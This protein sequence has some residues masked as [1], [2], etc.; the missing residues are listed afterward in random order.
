VSQTAL[1]SERTAQLL[2]IDINEG[3]WGGLGG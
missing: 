1:L 3:F 2:C